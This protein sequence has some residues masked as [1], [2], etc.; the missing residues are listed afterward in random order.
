MCSCMCVRVLVYATLTILSYWQCIAFISKHLIPC[1]PRKYSIPKTHVR[2]MY[3]IRMS[4]SFAL[5]RV[6]S[7]FN[8]ICHADKFNK[9]SVSERPKKAGHMENI[10][11]H[12]IRIKANERT[13][14]NKNKLLKIM[15]NCKHIAIRIPWWNHHFNLCAHYDLFITFGNF[16][17]FVRNTEKTLNLAF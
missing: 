14:L 11:H 3:H 7:G 15:L 4:I 1:N 5:L 16:E 6:S 12:I 8:A 10:C 9:L 2:W 13:Q 17:S